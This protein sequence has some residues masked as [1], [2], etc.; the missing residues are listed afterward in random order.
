[1]HSLSKAGC[2]LLRWGDSKVKVWSLDLGLHTGKEGTG[3]NAI[4]LRMELGWLYLVSK[5]YSRLGFMNQRKVL[6][7]A[8]GFYL[9]H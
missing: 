1:M 4:S 2:K 5:W 6:L 7:S 8:S 9:S 3:N